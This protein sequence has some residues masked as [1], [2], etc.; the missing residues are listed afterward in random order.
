VRFK[1]F[2]AGMMVVMMM[3]MMFFCYYFGSW[4]YVD[5]Y[6]EATLS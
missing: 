3:M 2:P 5:L 6:V 1:V 4:R